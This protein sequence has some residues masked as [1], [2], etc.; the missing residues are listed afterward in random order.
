MMREQ[1]PKPLTR[2]GAAC[3][4]KAEVGKEGE[5]ATQVSQSRYGRCGERQVLWTHLFSSKCGL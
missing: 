2:G 5:E 4:G 3:R 1:V